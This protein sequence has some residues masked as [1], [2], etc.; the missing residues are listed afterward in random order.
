MSETSD[1]YATIHPD[2]QAAL[3]DAWHLLPHALTV[4]ESTGFRDLYALIDYVSD[5]VRLAFPDVPC[6][7]GCSACC[8]DYGLPRTTA[9]EWRAIHR[10]WHEQLPADVQQAVLA[11]VRGI[12][13]DQVP[14]L[15]QERLRIQVPHTDARAGE[16]ALPQFGCLACPF[17]VEQR[18]T[19]YPVRPAICRAFGSFSVRVGE[20]LQ[21]FTCQMA[22][23]HMQVT[24]AA[25]GLPH[26]A[27]PVWGRFEERLYALNEGHGDVASLP[28]WV[29]AHLDGDQ[30]CVTV[31][32]QPDFARL[33]GAGPDGAG[34]AGAPQ[35]G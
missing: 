10:Y 23:D 18:C 12:Y 24:L 17:L 13:G 9:L 1:A 8:V 4:G 31:D 27:L 30:L 26:W 20:R 21:A 6:K 33:S 2:L 7:S 14:A 22:A 29:L 3:V 19:I 35:A 28:L 11:A 15:L 5:A 32:L 34:V 16:H 25:K